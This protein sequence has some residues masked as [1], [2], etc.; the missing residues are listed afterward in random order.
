MMLV[1]PALRKWKP[2]DQEFQGH[3]QLHTEFETSLDFIKPCLKTKNNRLPCGSVVELWPGM[4]EVPGSTAK[5]SP[6]WS[7]PVTQVT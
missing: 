2:Q 5:L 1:I 6:W 4:C 7:M 3:P